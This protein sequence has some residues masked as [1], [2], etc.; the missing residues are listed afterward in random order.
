MHF[1]AST[2]APYTKRERPC[3]TQL[4]IKLSMKVALQH[5]VQ[6]GQLG[7]APTSPGCHAQ[8]TAQAAAINGGGAG[9]AS[10]PPAH[11]APLTAAASTRTGHTRAPARLQTRDPRWPAAQGAAQAGQ[12]PPA[13]RRCCLSPSY[14]TPTRSRCRR[15][16][17]AAATAPAA[18]AAWA[19]RRWP[20]RPAPAC[21]TA[22]E[23]SRQHGH[24]WA[25]DRQALVAV[26]R[27]RSC[28]MCRRIN[29][30]QG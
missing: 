4:S 20:C 15:R 26:P 8:G 18:L 11:R 2:R 24:L 16:R 13:G 9:A 25:M 6:H 5:L 28:T 19:R 30:S 17:Q 23:R 29:P 21:D 27:I 14:C 12:T 3:G 10:A 22:C 7:V 1:T